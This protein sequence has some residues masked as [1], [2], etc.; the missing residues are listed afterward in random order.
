MYKFWVLALLGLVADTAPSLEALWPW[1]ALAKE[2]PGV[3]QAS[4]LRKLRPASV[5]KAQ[6]L[7]A[8]ALH[9]SY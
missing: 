9:A 1:L 3:G 4:G 2:S 6:H 5:D 8:G 7:E